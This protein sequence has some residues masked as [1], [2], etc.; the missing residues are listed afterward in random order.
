MQ[1]TNICN[2]FVEEGLEVQQLERIV[3]EPA[4]ASREL[5]MRDD[6]LANLGLVRIPAGARVR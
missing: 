4:K 6:A 2:V 1:D 3:P 5:G